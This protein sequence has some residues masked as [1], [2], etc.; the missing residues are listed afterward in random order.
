[1]AD[2]IDE[3]YAH[4]FSQT[5]D[6]AAR[7][8]AVAQLQ[9]AHEDLT[10]APLLDFLRQRRDLRI[11]GNDHIQTPTGRVPTVAIKTARPAAAIATDLEAHGVMAGAGDFYAVR[12]LAALG[13]DPDEGV[14]RL[15]FVHYTSVGEVDQLIKG[16][17][18]TLQG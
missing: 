4:H 5:V 9:R 17:D 12:T 11:L 13:C 6:A 1:M 18:A 7:A 14:L 16:L 2:Y 10:L 8:R 15:S 3:L